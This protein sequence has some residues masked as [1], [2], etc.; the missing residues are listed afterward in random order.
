M[1]LGRGG[2]PVVPAREGKRELE[3]DRFE[4]LAFLDHLFV[5]TGVD[6]RQYAQVSIRR[7]LHRVM[8]EDGAP[9]L[10]A[11]RARMTDPGA[12]RRIVHRLCVTV[13]SMFRDPEFWV[14]FR[15]EVVPRLRALPLIRIWHAGCATGE[16][17]YSL[18]IV[19]REE[20]LYTRSRIYATDVDE[21]ALDRARSATYPLDQVREYTRNYARAG[22]T[23]AFSEYYSASSDG[24][25]LRPGLRRHVILARHN[26]ATDESFNEFHVVLCRNVLIYFDEALQARSHDLLWRSLAPGAVLAL[27]QREIVPPNLDRRYERLDPA[28]KLYVRAEGV[29]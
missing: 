29:R 26:L 12:A 14:A 8:I 4:V 9:T 10:E 28:Q 6:F 7:R 1:S 17:A 27:G 21:S 11:L 13:T 22:G 25:E 3:L 24:V 15:R 19:L 16:E 20:G 5:R 2:D 23:R 18:A